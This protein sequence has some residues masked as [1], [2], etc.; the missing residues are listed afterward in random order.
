MINQDIAMGLV[1][2]TE[3]AAL[4]S[5]KYMGRG[6]KIAADQAAVDG[7]EKAFSMLPIRGTVVIGEG[8]MDN[9]PMLYIGQKL[10]IGKDDMMEMD[11]AVDPLDGTVLI[12]KGLPNA[13]AVVA[14][15]PKG[16]LLHAPDMYMKKIAVGAGAKGAI[17]INKSNKENIINVAM[18]L[19][20]DV[21]ELTVIVQE[22][23]RH[24]DIIRDARDVGARVKLFSEGDIAAVLACGFEDTGVDLMIGTGGAPEGVIAAA[25]I[26]CMGGDMQAKLVPQC[27]EEIKRCKDMGIKDVNGVLY[28]ND[29]VKSD[30]VYF[31]ATGITDCDLLKGVVYSKN[32]WAST[33][34]VV[35]RSK[36]GT[37]RFVNANHQL[38]RSNLVV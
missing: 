37:I 5:A 19:N 16:S 23:E 35:M 11:I 14:M 9:A 20:K 34:S 13:I 26:K 3:A 32:N 15:G 7:M 28:I 10:G 36:T 31:A 4:C 33:N 6:D 12:A 29:L 18:A 38:L 27:E 1:R 25:A 22:R 21:S 2:V 8:E 17:D 24:E 30:D